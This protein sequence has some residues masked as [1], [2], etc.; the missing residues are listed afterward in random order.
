MDSAWTPTTLGDAVTIV[1]GG[2]PSTEVPAYWGGSIRWMASG[3]VHLRR[4]REV[5]GRI[6][7][8]GL[9]S[10][11]ATLVSPPAVAVAL[12]GQ[13][14]T[15]GKVALLEV[16]LTTNQSIA[17]LQPP[18]GRV[19]ATYLFHELDR[20]YK[21]LRTRSSGGGRAGLSRRVLAEV[22]LLLP[23]LPEQR[24][25]AE[26]LDTL[27]EAIRKTEEI[28]AKLKQVKQGLLH[29]LLTRGIDDNGELRDPHRHPEQFKDSPLG[30]IPK[31]WEVARLDSIGRVIDSLHRTPTFAVEGRAMV[32]VT[33][34]K[35]GLLSL[36]KCVRVSPRVFEEFTRNHKPRAGDIVLSRVGTYGVPSLAI[37]AEPFCM[38]QNTVVVTGLEAA[39]FLFSFLQSGAAQAQFERATVGSSQSTLSLAAIRACLTPVPPRAERERFDDIVANHRQHVLRTVQSLRKLR[40]LKNGLTEDLLTGSVR[41]TKLLEDAALRVRTGTQ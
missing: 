6:T 9:A 3:D 19:D 24:Q 39:H 38:G 5:P 29:D 16:P 41:V 13:G 18:T 14:K 32:R 15:R 21:E 30:R 1:L 17:A 25:I 26:I 34:I 35:G 27:D 12:A 33:D 28:I 2:T 4:V 10:S 36:D 40:L 23:P 7:E 20:R 22:P 11:N 31:G 37:T 8:L